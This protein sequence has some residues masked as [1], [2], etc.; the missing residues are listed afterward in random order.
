LRL[1]FDIAFGHLRTRK[2]QTIV[3]TLGVA[4]GVGFSM[5]MGALLEGSQRDFIG[6]IV[7]YLPH[8]VIKDEFREPQTQPVY[9]A[10][11]GALVSI[12]GVKP[13]EE[14]RGIKDP[15]RKLEA[16]DAIPSLRAAP[17]MRAQVFFRYGGKSVP[18]AVMGID[19]DRERLASRLEKDIFEGSLQALRGAPNGLLMGVGLAKKLGVSVGGTLTAVST[20]GAVMKMKVVG[21]Y[22]TGIVSLDNYETYA[23]IKKAQILEAKPNVV[24]QIRMRID[25][26][27]GAVET[28][29]ELEARW[30]YK[31]ESWQEANEGFL[32]FFVVRNVIMYVTVA[33]ILIVASFGIFNVVSTVV[34]EKTRDIAILKSMGFSA[35]DIR[36]IFLIEGLA[37]GIVGTLIGWALGVGLVQALRQVKFKMQMVTD[38]QGF[39]LSLT[40][41]HF[42]VAGSVAILS[43]VMAAWLPAR[44]ASKVN[45]VE[46][47][48]GAA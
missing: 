30:G 5:A 48:R 15:M 10:Y 33:A 11:P 29:R 27:T 34:Y 14:L 43:A 6:R 22:R 36:V 39:I 25:E 23:L 12:R 21:M 24:N 1:L 17:S 20:S 44:K 26:A 2:R 38:V 3:S 18:A 7:D 41:M 45:P 37:V 32:S 9:Q 35:H 8:V 4:M 42:A 19:P 13:Q 40:W 47:I 16:L 31:A 28:A 46:I